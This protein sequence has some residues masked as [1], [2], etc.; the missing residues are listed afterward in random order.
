MEN[1]STVIIGS[2]SIVPEKRVSNEDFQNH[3][4]LQENGEAFQHETAVL[5]EKLKEITGIEERRYAEENQVNSDLAIVAAKKAIEDAQID[6]E[7]LDLIIVGTNFGDIK[8]G[9]IQSDFLPGIATKVKHGLKIKNPAT[10]AFDIIF[11]CPGWLQALIIANTYIKA[12]SAK[13]C[14]VIGSETLSRLIDP[15]DRD[16]M[17]YSDGAGAVVIEAQQA[18]TKTGLLATATR[19]DTIDEAYY[20]HW[21]KS[22]LPEADEN[23]GYIKMYGRKIYEYAITHVPTALKSV[24]DEAN[25]DISEV[26]KIMIHQANE[27]MDI[28]IVKRFYRL[29]KSKVPENIMPMTI[30]K[31]GNSSVA[32]I[33]TLYD[34]VKHGK[35]EGHE[36]NKGDIILFASIGAGM[37]INAAVYRV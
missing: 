32:T 16:S 36:L 30:Q 17:I 19:T 12:G 15:Y 24:L 2:G 7:T 35:V 21:G 11:G 3:R 33:P 37:H 26:K 8:H 1:L 18:E 13:R 4:F 6:P 10:I 29:F 23:I 25:V 31:F 28:A 34:R 22:Y 20:L 14:L 9:S 27:K 5:T